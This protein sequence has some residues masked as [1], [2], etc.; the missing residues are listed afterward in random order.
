MLNYFEIA[1]DI[2]NTHADCVRSGLSEEQTAAALEI[3]SRK[4]SAKTI[5]LGRR[6]EQER[7][8]IAAGVMQKEVAG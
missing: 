2:C 4:Y 7:D 6:F 1:K 3:V 8:A 5:L